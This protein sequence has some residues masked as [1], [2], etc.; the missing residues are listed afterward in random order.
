MTRLFSSNKLNETTL[1]SLIEA[2][3]KF[4]INIELHM[5]RAH[6]KEYL[7]WISIIKTI[8]DRVLYNSLIYI[9]N[10]LVSESL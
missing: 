9:D 10:Q 3:L 2:N 8:T 7:G 5:I 6:E 1:V 4:L